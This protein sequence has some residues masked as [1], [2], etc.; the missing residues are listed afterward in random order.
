[1]K[2]PTY[3]KNNVKDYSETDFSVMKICSSAKNTL[4]EVWYYGD[5]F[6]VPNE[7]QEY[8]VGTDSVPA[9]ITAKDPETN[10]EILIFDGAK[11]GYDSMFCDVYTE[12]QINNRELKRMEIPVSPLILELGYSIDYEDEKEDYE[13]DGNG[14]VILVD[15]R[16]IAWEDLICDGFDYLAL[17]Y[18]S[19]TGEKIQFADFE[20]A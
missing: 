14:N 10:E 18:I 19:E 3:L 12:E 13:F 8:I 20:L 16:R 4:L 7:E 1:M 9:K 17:S 6:K 15:D 11:H 2:I 5:L